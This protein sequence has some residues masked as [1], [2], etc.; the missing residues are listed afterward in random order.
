LPDLNNKIKAIKELINNQASDAKTV[1]LC[2]YLDTAAKIIATINESGVRTFLITGQ[3]MQKAEILNEFKG[4]DGKAVLVM[5][6]VG[7]R[8]ID[9]P[10]AKLL[11][12]YDSINTTKTMYQRMK[13]T[14]GGLVLCL[15]YQDTFEERKISRL[16]RDIS[17]R[18]PWSSIIE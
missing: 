4:Y 6:S 9:L 2:S 10:Q 17:S 1:I 12:V 7:E 14:R 13:R 8:D 16:L 11:I 18:Y 5:T 3:V 15:Y